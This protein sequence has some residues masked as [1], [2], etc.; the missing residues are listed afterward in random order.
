M[1]A[2]VHRMKKKEIVW[3]S[4]HRCKHGHDFLEHYSCYLAENP[5]KERIGFL[6]LECSNLHASFG[7]ILCFSLK[8]KGEDKIYRRV[9]TASDLRTCLD[10]KVVRQC[11]KNMG[12]FDRIV[13]FYGTKFDIPFLRTRAISLGVPFPE[14]GTMLHKDVYYIA[15]AKL[16]LHSNRLDSVCNTLFGSTEKTRIEPDKWIKALMGDAKSLVYIQ[17]HCDKDV[18]ELEKVYNALIGYGRLNDTSV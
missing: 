13:T 12:N 10:E 1:S 18:T 17:D 16:R 14:Y 11:I 7:I 2:P 3:L 6:D 8:T 9:V 4:T 15:R 5:D